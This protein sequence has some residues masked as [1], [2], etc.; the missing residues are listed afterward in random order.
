MHNRENLAR[1]PTPPPLPECTVESKQAKQTDM[2]CMTD[3]VRRY[4]YWLASVRSQIV[5][6]GPGTNCFTARKEAVVIARRLHPPADEA[7][8]GR[9]KGQEVAWLAA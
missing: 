4:G 3:S 6:D 2:S 9:N 1:Q 8:A 5:A 7:P